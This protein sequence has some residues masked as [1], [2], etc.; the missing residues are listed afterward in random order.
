MTHFSAW[1]L[2]METE[3]RRTLRVE[4][5]SVSLSEVS[6]WAWWHML[7]IPALKRQG[8]IDLYELE[9]SMIYIMRPCLK[10]NHNNK[11]KQKTPKLVPWLPKKT[12]C[13]PWVPPLACCVHTRTHISV[14]QKVLTGLEDPP[15]LAS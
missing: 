3:A 13:N 4:V 11:N 2:E 15:A 6:R 7:L 10:N 14:N 12:C 9:V 8:Q 1:C 5:Q